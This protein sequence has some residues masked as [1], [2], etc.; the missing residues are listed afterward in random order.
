MRRS[1]RL[2]LLIAG[3]IS[4]AW[5]GALA[6]QSRA[7]VVS[8]QYES[9]TLVVPIAIVALRSD[10][11]REWTLGVVGWT[12]GADWRHV[13][14]PTRRRHLFVHVTPFNANSSDYFYSDGERD[15]ASEYD[16]SSIEVGGGIEL[17]HRRGWV[18][19]YRAL[20]LYEWVSGLPADRGG[21]GWNRPFAGAEV[22][23]HYEHLT[24]EELFGSRWEGIKVDGRARILTGTRS[25][26]QFSLRAGVGARA[27]PMHYSG[28]GEVFGG[29]H[30]DTV[31]AMLVGGSWDLDFP[32]ALVGYRYG[33]FRLSRGATLGGAVHLRL[34]RAWEL[35]TRAGYLRT[36]GRS[37]YGAGVEMSSIWKGVTVNA[38]IGLPKDGLTAG[39]WD[40][41]VIFATCSAAILRD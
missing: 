23:E 31:S 14:R 17:T 33:E 41:A 8:L 27:G 36:S 16:A 39:E 5:P 34:S 22:T 38:G 3:L 28:R 26:S 12:L 15:E 40:H 24:A 2:P 19:G 1:G 6:A 11:G 4:A 30:L 18:G 25:W 32:G 10:E 37:E 13:D 29:H 20:A 21:E 9:P 35:G 7:A